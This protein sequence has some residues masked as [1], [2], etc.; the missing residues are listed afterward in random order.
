MS[1][2]QELLL[3]APLLCLH[4]DFW[5]PF[6]KTVLPILSDQCLS[7]CLSVTFVFVYCG[8]TVGWIRMPLGTE[9]GQGHIVLDGDPALP[10]KAAQQPPPHFRNLR[11][12]A[13]YGRRQIKAPYKLRPMSI[14]AERPDGSGCHLVWR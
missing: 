11:M 1:N 14:V 9:I 12:Q 7:V 8:Q 5:Q 2:G 3:V 4:I 6:V 13:L 10:R